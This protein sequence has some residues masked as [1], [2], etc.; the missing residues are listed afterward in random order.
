MQR[1]PALGG[2]GTVGFSSISGGIGAELTGGDFWWGAATGAIVGAFNHLQGE[3][4][5]SRYYLVFDGKELTVWDSK[6][7]RI[8]GR[9]NATSGKGE[10]MNKGS[11]QNDKN[12]GP[13][14]SGK[15]SYDKENWKHQSR[16]RQIY[17]IVAGNG[18]WG[19][20]NVSLDVVYNANEDRHSFYLHGSFFK[21]SAGCIDAGRSIRHIYNFTKNQKTTYIY[22]RY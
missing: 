7:N 3:I 10:H 16:V 21:G 14:P 5:R 6:N 2:I 4:R 8:V 12:K 19:D 17:N 20:Y 11:S 22:V 15:Y 18:D 9:I 13:T 1:N